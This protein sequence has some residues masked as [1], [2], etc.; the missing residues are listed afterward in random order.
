MRNKNIFSILVAV[1]FCFSLFLHEDCI[2]ATYSGSETT[3]PQELTGIDL[4]KTDPIA[5]ALILAE[6]RLKQGL[7]QEA[8]QYVQFVISRDKQ[9][10]KAHGILGTIYAL[11]GQ[12]KMAEDELTFFKGKGEK[13]FYVDLIEAIVK[14]QEKK[15]KEAEHHLNLAL[16]K[17]PGH[18]VAIYYS[19]SL[20]SLPKTIRERLKTPL[21]P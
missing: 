17:E 15:F 11:G 3:L 4:T 18:P 14:A 10:N 16:Q 21:K 9:N 7:W 12:K 20:R 6:G 8:I 13:G 5:A 2:G 1:L 19:G